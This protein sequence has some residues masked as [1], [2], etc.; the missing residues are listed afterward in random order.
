MIILI[1]VFYAEFT[2]DQCP[3]FG[4][5]SIKMSPDGKMMAS[6]DRSGN[7]RVHD[8]NTWDLLTYQEAHDSEILSIDLTTPKDKG[9]IIF[10]LISLPST[11]EVI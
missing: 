6:G 2:E 3:D 11:N 5:R 9:T 8:M 1:V 7:L 4:I 10:P